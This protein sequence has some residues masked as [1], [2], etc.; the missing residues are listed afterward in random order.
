MSEQPEQ[1][2]S[3][4]ADAQRRWAIPVPRTFQS[5]R[6]YNFRLFW[7]GQLMSL[8]GTWMQTVGQAWLVLELTQSPLALGTVTAL[9]FL[10][11]LV[12]TLFAGVIVDRLPK[13]RLLLV[14][15]SAALV[16]ALALALLV[17]SGLVQL[18]HVYL[19]AALLGLVNAFDNPT[20]QAFIIEMVGRE[21]L[22]NAV[23]LNSTLFN[24]ARVVGPA[25]GGIVIASVGLAVCFYVNALSFL[26]MLAGLLLMREGLLRAPPRRPAGRVLSQLVEG[27]SYAVRTPA[28]LL[29]VILMGT[30]GT[31]GYNFTVVLP[32]LARNVLGVGAEGFGALTSAMGA[33]SLAAALVLATLRRTSR[34]T[35]FLGAASFTLLLAV[36]AGSRWYAVSLVVM[37]LLGIAG[38]AFTATANALLQLSVPDVL[39]G[40]ILSLYTLLFLGS[41]PI[42]GLVTGFLADRWG[43]QMALG[44]ESLVCAVGVIGGLS[45]YLAIR[46]Q[47]APVGAAGAVEEAGEF[48]G[49]QGVP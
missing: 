6:N 48:G 31:F 38:L 19:L 13:R 40:R 23:A 10:P 47:A 9:Q 49:G 20:R 43:I 35:L 46:R 30:L 25:L 21:D 37:V 45:Y 5:L 18:W 32:L 41:T 16:Q 36:L 11:V 4:P 17:S 33:G 12:L 8:I 39:R 7:F 34:R 29:I 28:V 24:G 27:I 22:V 1:R 14:T 44:L 3:S 42:G 26:A 15:Q 2:F